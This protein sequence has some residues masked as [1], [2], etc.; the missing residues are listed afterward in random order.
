MEK[1]QRMDFEVI[2]KK[3]KLSFAGIVIS[4]ALAISCCIAL[5][6]IDNPLD[7]TEMEKIINAELDKIDYNF[8]K[9]RRLTNG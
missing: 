6:R 1:V 2:D 7:K 5:F 8:V 4:S 3:Q 9:L